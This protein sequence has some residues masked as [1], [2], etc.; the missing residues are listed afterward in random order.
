MV[1][2]RRKYTLKLDHSF[3]YIFYVL[4]IISFSLMEEK[5][6]LDAGRSRASPRFLLF[7]TAP[8]S[9][10][11]SPDVVASLTLTQGLNIF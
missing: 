9:T 3:C 2:Q 10:C 7:F 8:H 6:S 11:I 1:Y 4:K 5:R